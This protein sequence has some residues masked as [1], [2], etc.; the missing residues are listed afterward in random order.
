MSPNLKT[1][2]HD[3]LFFMKDNSEGQRLYRSLIDGMELDVPA[4][5]LKI[6]VHFDLIDAIIFN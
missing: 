3:F 6:T 1:Y 4:E 5:G 2:P